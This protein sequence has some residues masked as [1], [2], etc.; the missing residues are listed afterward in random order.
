MFFVQVLKYQKRQKPQIS[1]ENKKVVRT[2]GEVAG[3]TKKLGTVL[4]LNYYA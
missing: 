2:K 1:E 4:D 3:E